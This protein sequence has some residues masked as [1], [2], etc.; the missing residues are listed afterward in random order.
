MRGVF[1]RSPRKRVDK[2]LPEWDGWR[3]GGELDGTAGRPRVDLLP[4]FPRLQRPCP[5]KAPSPPLPIAER[6]GR[7]GPRTA[8]AATRSRIR[9][10][11]ARG[12]RRWPPQVSGP[13]RRRGQARGD[14]APNPGRLVF[15]GADEKGCGVDTRRSRKRF[16]QIRQCEISV[17]GAGGMGASK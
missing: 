12:A 3:A 11:A 1:K 16:S 2:V 15:Q 9:R 14:P 17:N 5:V 13:S 10:P 4:A 7:R 8:P 6:K